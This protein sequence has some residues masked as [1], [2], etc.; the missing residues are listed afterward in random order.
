MNRFR[1]SP[2]LIGLLRKQKV[3]FAIGTIA[4]TFF[5]LTF[6]A[7]ANNEPLPDLVF[8]QIPVD[9][10]PIAMEDRSIHL[11]FERYVDGCRIVSYSLA[12]PEH[13][14]VPLTEDFL[15]ACDPDVSFDGQ[16]ILFAGKQT[17]Q[18]YWQIW[19]MDHDGANKVQITNAT[20][21]CLSPLYVGALFFLNDPAPTDQIVYVGSE[22]GGVNEYGYG[23][24]YSLYACNLEGQ[25]VHR[26]TYN[27]S[28]DFSPAVLPNGRIVYSSWNRFGSRFAPTGLFSLL[29]VSN[30]GTDHLPFYGNFEKPTFK[31]MTRVSSDERVYFIETDQS[32]WLGGGDLS[33]VALR[34]PLRT[35]QV[36]SRDRNG[37][38]HSPCPLPDGRLLASYRTASPDS[39]FGIHRVSTETGQ[40]LEE[41]YRENG[42]HSINAHVLAP[43]P[44]VKGR[45]TVV[46][47]QRETGVFYCLDAYMTDREEIEADSI[48][49]VR[50][51]EGVPIR[52]NTPRFPV[53]HPSGVA[54]PGSNQYSGTLYGLRRIVGVAPVEKDGSF[55]I[56]VPASTPLTFQLLDENNLAIRTQRQWT[57]VMPKEHR[58]CIGCHED[59]ELSPPNRFVDALTK[60][61]VNL[62]LPPERRRTVDFRHQIA[63]IIRQ[64]CSTADCHAAGKALPDLNVDKIVDHQNQ[65]A[66]FSQAYENLLMEIP[67]REKEH[68]VIPGNAKE[69]PLIWHLFG[70]RMGT[71]DTPYS[72]AVKLMPPEEKLTPYERI[73]L[74]EWVDLGAQWDCMTNR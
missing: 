72:G 40:R 27:L 10:E 56:E 2:F 11:P 4:L 71:S 29:A 62:N 24:A 34:R 41:I 39:V 67:G 60:P 38:Y 54:G 68:Y 73:Q 15:S 64:K 36:L 17:E 44:H 45:A 59:R 26:I 48:K 58:G 18:S 61:A 28:A 31:E 22:H 14:P 51:I 50:V 70:K 53:S 7:A 32:T 5:S 46:D 33:Y 52:E 19:R 21:D 35:H 20:G 66:Y 69:S 42:R 49:R 3:L 74:I 43:H 65:G 16:K 25:N 9:N 12:H 6:A 63:P 13:P 1:Q 57:W 55:H 37:Y 47:F 8:T 23:P 30:D